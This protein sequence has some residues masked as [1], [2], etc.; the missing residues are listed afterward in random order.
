MRRQAAARPTKPPRDYISPEEAAVEWEQTL[1]NDFKRAL[2]SYRALQQAPA[3][4]DVLERENLD[5]DLLKDK[6]RCLG[7]LA[8]AE[9]EALHCLSTQ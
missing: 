8:Q 9:E 2:A 6:R 4:R 5:D 3:E 7:A 1:E